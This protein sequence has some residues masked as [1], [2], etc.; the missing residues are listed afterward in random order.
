MPADR[1]T[2]GWVDLNANV[3]THVGPKGL[4]KSAANVGS[5]PSAVQAYVSAAEY[6]DKA[7]HQTVLTLTAL[8]ITMRDTEQGGGAKIY[9]FPEGRICKLGGIGAIAVTTTSELAT[10]L[11][12]GKTCNWGVGSVTQANATVATTEQDFVNVTA[13]TSGT[14]INVANAV[15][16]GVGPGVLASHDGTTTP[17]AAFMNLAIAGAGDIDGDA[18]VTVTGTITLSWVYVG[19]Y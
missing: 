11:K 19:D 2:D 12:T 4:D 18:T 14:T 9:T 10:T 17:I 13:W 16:K 6:G 15:T 1:N 5:I 3:R 8:P 7:F